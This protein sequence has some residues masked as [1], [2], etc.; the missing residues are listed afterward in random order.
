MSGPRY[1]I[2]QADAVD[3]KRMSKTHLLVLLILG[4]HS[5]NRGWAAIS[6]KKTGE[7][8]GVRRETINR[9]MR[10]LVSWGY[11][12]KKGQKETKRSIC[13]YRVIMDRG[14]PE[15]DAPDKDPAPDIDRGCE[16]EVTQGCEITPGCDAEITG[17][18][19]VQTSHG[20]VTSE[21]H[22]ITTHRT[23]DQKERT[24]V[25]S[26]KRKSN[27]SKGSRLADDWTL[28]DDWRRWAV[29]ELGAETRTVDW[30]AD[31][32]HDYWLG[33]SG[34]RGIKRSWQTTWRNWMR[35][36][37]ER[38]GKPPKSRS[39]SGYRYG[40]SDYLTYRMPDGNSFTTSVPVDYP[41]WELISG[42]LPE[43]EAQTSD[44]Q[45]ALL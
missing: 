21:D 35:K 27:S 32:F 5:N 33:V 14:E 4:R 1:S 23:N 26:K 19:E 37:M 8:L 40:K 39:S 7:K 43:A 2:I 38:G 22:T 10:D 9:A 25:L 31:K 30:E 13:F 28:P 18:R 44:K 15:I 12:E 3:D 11:V 16:T 41:G 34:Q 6:Q 17:G 45:E 20:G 29:H 24:K 42:T 36:A